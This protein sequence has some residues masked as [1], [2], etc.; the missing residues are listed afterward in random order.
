MK[1]IIALLLVLVL[2]VGMF[3]CAPKEEEGIKNTLQVGFSR[4]DITPKTSCQLAG[5]PG[6]E[7]RWSANVLDP[8]CATCVAITDADGNTLLVYTIDSLYC[9]GE[10]LLKRKDISKTTGIPAQNIMMAATH[11]HS[12]PYS[13]STELW[14]TYYVDLLEEQLVSAAVEALAD[15]KPAEIFTASTR[16]N[17]MTFVRHYL[18]NDGTI[19]GPNFGNT[20]SGYVKH[21]READNE[22]Q[23]IRFKR[24]E[25][26]DVV[27]VNWQTHPLRTGN[28]TATD[29]SAD[30]PGSMRVALEELTG[31]HVAYF[32]GAHGDL[33]PYSYIAG[34]SINA[35][36][37]RQGE[38]MAQ[39]AF[40]AMESMTKVEPGKIQLIKKDQEVQV[41][42]GVNTLPIYAFS[43]GDVAFVTAPY[44]MFDTN[45]MYVKENSPYDM[46]FILSNANGAGSYMAADW[47]Y[48]D[49]IVSYEVGKGNYAKGSGEIFASAMVDLLNEIYPNRK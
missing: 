38:L 1:K 12:A 40:L 48:Y 8:I 30:L 44:E 27:L 9:T 4:K 35:D 36:Y 13:S 17:N 31:G 29:L 23:L 34:K 18:M 7:G 10:F 19:S 15:R 24:E 20:Q 25:G 2:S 28:A 32:N 6:F 47:A 46:T 11:T 39:Q 16:L 5:Y 45:G 43:I 3:G 49:D 26:A 22:M 33:M 42:S 37:I 21:V 14:Q 41:G